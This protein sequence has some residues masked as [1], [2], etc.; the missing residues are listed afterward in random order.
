MAMKLDEDL[1]GELLK[2]LDSLQNLLIEIG[3]KTYHFDLSNDSKDGA[4]ELYI[5]YANEEQMVPEERQIPLK[6]Q[7]QILTA[8]LNHIKDKIGAPKLESEN[9]DNAIR[10]SRSIPQMKGGT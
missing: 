7:Y 2:A 8:V 6:T 10:I 5:Y 3:D 4:Y 9:N 1:E